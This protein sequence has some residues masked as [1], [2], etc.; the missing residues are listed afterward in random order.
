MKS[1]ITRIMVCM[2]AVMALCLS[3][4]SHDT[5]PQQPK[6]QPTAKTVKQ[7][8]KKAQPQPMYI[9]MYRYDNFPVSQA[10]ALRSELEKVY[11]HVHLVSSALPLP[12]KEYYKEGNRYRARGLVEDLF[13]Y[14]HGGAA[15]G[16]TTQIIYHPNE[17]S[18]YWG[19]FGFSLVGYHSAVISSMVPKTHKRQSPEDMRKLMLH[20]LGHAFGL[21]HCNDQHCFMVDFEH[22]N[23][24]SQTPSFCSDCKRFLNSKGWKL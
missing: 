5:K 17:I 19:I 12:A 22:G 14:R 9:Y 10:Q 23:K 8:A 7:P 11:P 24:F 2:M 13:P 18:P 3:A 1:R 20:E 16:M 21:Y 4:C 6:A 15:L